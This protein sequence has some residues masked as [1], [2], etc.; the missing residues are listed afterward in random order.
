MTC[1]QPPTGPGRHLRLLKED[2]EADRLRLIIAQ[3]VAL[4]T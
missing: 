1:L 2:S 3:V 4:N